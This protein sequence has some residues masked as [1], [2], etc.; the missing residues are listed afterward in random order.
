MDG[1][2]SRKLLT[3]MGRNKPDCMNY[4]YWSNAG[5]ILPRHLSQCAITG[6]QLRPP[7][8]HTSPSARS[9]RSH[10]HQ[11]R[12]WLR[13][14]RHQPSE[15]SPS[16]HSYHAANQRLQ[17]RLIRRVLQSNGRTTKSQPT[18][19]RRPHHPSLRGWSA[20]NRGTQNRLSSCRH[21]IDRHTIRKPAGI[22]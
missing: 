3:I 19:R 11:L 7:S 5:I 2:S 1:G 16:H 9:H 8:A 22:Y 17:T 18:R 12:L 15:L 10:R 4:L 6:H 20:R 13:S 21:G 14:H